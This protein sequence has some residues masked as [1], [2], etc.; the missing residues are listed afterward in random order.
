MEHGARMS[1]RRISMRSRSPS[2]GW[3]DVEGS[4]VMIS[5]A[6]Q[7]PKACR[8]FHPSGHYA[9]VACY[10]CKGSHFARDCPLYPCDRC[11]NFGHPYGMSWSTSHTR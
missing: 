5:Y 10:G 7:P 8:A 11:Y 4:T 9:K 6:Q 3:L 2:P 1:S